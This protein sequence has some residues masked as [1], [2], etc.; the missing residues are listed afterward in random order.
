MTYIKLSNKDYHVLGIWDNYT[1]LMDNHKFVISKQVDAIKSNL[2]TQ[3][4]F[5]IL[6][7]TG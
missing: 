5:A 3:V 6:F 1:T 4:I 7:Q 2:D